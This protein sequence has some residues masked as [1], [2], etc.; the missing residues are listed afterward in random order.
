[1]RLVPL[2]TAFTLL[3]L[4]K[5]SAQLPELTSSDKATPIK[6]R[7]LD[8]GIK[9]IGTRSATT[10]VMTFHNPTDKVLEGTFNLP[11][12]DGANVIRYALDINGKMR[13]GVPV[14]KAKATEIF[15][16][17]ERRKIDP[18]ILVKTDGNIFRT[19]IFPLPAHGDRSI[20][21][22]YEQDLPLNSSN[23][24]LYHLPLS[25]KDTLPKFSLS[26]DVQE[27]DHTPVL[28]STPITELHFILSKGHFC[29]QEQREKIVLNRPLSILMPKKS[30]EVESF[31]QKK[32]GQY[33]FYLQTFIPPS[34]KVKKLP[35]RLALIWDNSL[36]GLYRNTSKEI[37]FLEAYLKRIGTATIELYTLNNTFQHSGTYIVQGG[38]SKQLDEKLKSMVYDGGTDYS[39]IK[40]DEA[41]ET[42]LFSDGLSTLSDINKLESLKLLY[43]V[44]SSTKANFNTL[45]SMAEE[46]GGVFINLSTRSIDEAVVELSKQT[47]LFLG[48]KEDK[49]LF[50]YY[51]NA[52]TSVQNGF[53]M[54]G[55][56]EGPPT[57]VTLQFGYG[58]K[59][60]M[61]KTVQL[62]YDEYGV[63]D[64]DLSRL[65]AQKKIGELEKNYD[66]NKDEILLLGK[67]HSIVTQNTSLLVLEDVMDYVRNE[68]EP[69]LE[70]R[71]E[72]KRL[73]KERRDELSQSRQNSLGNAI[74]Y[75]KELWQWWNTTYP[76]NKKEVSKFT[77]PRV[78]SDSEISTDRAR[79]SISGSIAVPPPPPP[80]QEENKVMDVQLEVINLEKGEEQSTALQGKAAGVQLREVVVTGYNASK[81]ARFNNSIGNNSVDQLL[82]VDGK[83]STS[84]PTKEQIEAMETIEPKAGVALYG[85]RAINDVIV[86]TTKGA[87]GEDPQI[88]LEEKASS[89]QYMKVLAKAPR[90]QQYQT[91]LE[92]RDKNLLNPT[93]YYD[94]ASFFLKQ[95]RFLGLQ[96]LTNL[97]ELDFQNHE[98][99]KL[100]GF[101]L[102]EL[103]EKDE[104]LF[105]FRKM[106]QW[107]P[108]EPQSYR[109]YGLALAENEEYQA[110]LDTLCLALTKEY[111][112][113][114]MS[115]Y[116][117]IEETII[118]E[119]NNLIAR[120]R[121]YLNVSGID[122]KLLH[123]MPVDIRVVMNWNMNDTDM[124]LWVTDPS[125]EKC[126]YSNRKTTVGGRLS[127]DFTQGYGPE[128]F[129][130]K[131]AQKGKY[132]IQVHYYGESR[133]KIAGKT[134]LLVEV[135]TNYGKDKEQRKS[136]TLQLEGEE[137]E[138][139]YLGEFIF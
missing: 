26:V 17:V 11:L 60:A 136:I 115:N 81:N 53:S 80:Q 39:K 31:V 135:F 22:A 123:P 76:V 54:A 90:R 3:W 104:Q 34:T 32:N 67:Q 69:P 6:L 137:R 74:E 24:L 50:E 132:K 18:G 37:E 116:G 47:L 110:A 14:E 108:Q 130:L 98:L 88:S 59:V 65:F 56:L 15:E 48:I 66:K 35:K 96:V 71:S 44:S 97:G 138:G 58:R 79:Q 82:V 126:F 109:D 28:Q 41:E 38:E 30:T 113:D 75:S 68:V 73:L 106:L 103:G 61:E 117:G 129:L 124:D 27:R 112:S 12:P 89:A 20:I 139:I 87:K 70:L 84:M 131:S 8:I 19:R 83:L 33:Y 1:M 16:S 4:N 57:T 93:F 40:F 78:V 9:I 114:I 111:N 85:S 121:P 29:A 52:P 42:L 105:V 62:S 77:P 128:Q 36:S 92:L 101:K 64:W 122:R 133:A 100:F 102:K 118:M 99:H 86:V 49:A 55:K 72:Y 127:E 23:E 10:F 7:K 91:Y 5:T 2:L 119:I 134:T 107:R 13:E 45:R 21:I 94:V 25:S 43:T 63:E 46:N 95:D 120:H 125:G 51:P